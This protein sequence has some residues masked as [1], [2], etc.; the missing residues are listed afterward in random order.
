MPEDRT[1]GWLDAAAVALGPAHSTAV[2]ELAEQPMDDAAHLG[3]ANGCWMPVETPRT[4][5]LA[6]LC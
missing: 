6:K 5:T 1:L 3:A 4:I 2:G